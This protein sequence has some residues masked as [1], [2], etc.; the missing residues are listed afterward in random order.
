V[1]IL[2]CKP[3]PDVLTPAIGRDW[4]IA[5]KHM[6]KQHKSQSGLLSQLHDRD[7][8]PNSVP[9]QRLDAC[10]STANA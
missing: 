3:R 8:A 5:A 2:R 4:R 9:K 1:I 6:E 10:Q 7:A